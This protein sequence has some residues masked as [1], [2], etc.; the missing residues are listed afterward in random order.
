M[1]TVTE[2]RLSAVLCLCLTTTIGLTQTTAATARVKQGELAGATSAQGI[3]V[4]KGIPFAAPPVGELRWRPPA[5]PKSWSGVRPATA[6]GS[7]CMQ[8]LSRERL[9]WTKEFMVQNEDSED[10]LFLNVWT[11]SLSAAAKLPVVV[12]L[13]GGGFNEG[14]GDIAAYDGENLARKGIVVVTINYRVGIFGFL[15]HPELTA[16]SPEHSSGN[17]GILD[18]IAALKWVKQNAQ[19]FGGDPSKVTVWGQSAGAMSVACLVASPLANGLFRAAMADSAISHSGSLARPIKEA[20][21]QGEAFAKSKGAASIHDLRAIPAKDLMA[22]APR[23]S[24]VI[25]GWMLKDNPVKLMEEGPDADVPLIT[26]NVAQDGRAVGRPVRTIQEFDEHVQSAYGQFGA[27]LLKLYPVDQDSNANAVW[28]ELGRD[29]NRASMYEFASRRSKTHKAPV[30]TYFFD[31]AI[32]W[33]EHPEYGAFH[34]SE[35]AYFFD[36]LQ[37]LDRPWEEKDR[38]VSRIA[39]GYVVDFVKTGRPEGAGVPA[40]PAVHGQ[41]ETMRL[42]SAFGPMKVVDS[43]AKQEL[44]HRILSSPQASKLPLL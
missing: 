39:S 8:N 24:P 3:H 38:E 2:L 37:Q 5:E 18:Q 31:R 17:Y 13:H 43:P 4:F 28:E 15:A 42:G 10:C 25:D 36:N 32:P 20:E 27:E 35:L 11:P 7:A 23:S 34:T 9:P 19:A 33:P 22:S 26:G 16:E 21:A 41:A 14:S 29:R 30:Y 40:W 44:W 6:F 1:N 12:F